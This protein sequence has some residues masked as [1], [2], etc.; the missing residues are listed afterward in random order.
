MEKIKKSLELNKQFVNNISSE[1]LEMLIS[2]FDKYDTDVQLLQ[3]T[4]IASTDLNRVHHADFE[5]KGDLDIVVNNI[6]VKDNLRKSY[7][8]TFEDLEPMLK[9]SETKFYDKPKSKFHK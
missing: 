9:F 7:L 2:E 3:T 1:E 8:K 4:V 6:E 5:I